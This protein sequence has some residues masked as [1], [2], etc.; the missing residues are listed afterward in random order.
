ME[1]QGFD[2]ALEEPRLMLV[3]TNV[4]L[5]VIQ[6]DATWA[7]WSISQL[8]SQAKVHQLV[9]N[10]VIYAEISLAFE[11]IETL[12]KVL[13][14]MQLPLMELPKPALFLA[15]KAFLAY[16]RRG[17]LKRNVLSDFYIGAHAAVMDWPVL[18]RDRS[19][20][21]TYFPVVKLIAP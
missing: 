4:L 21:E 6:D 11:R 17:G 3:D 14:D 8:R 5:D 16:R 2:E 19:K 15:A 18:T 1:N 20:Y 9:I 10:P 7:D 12:D 13:E